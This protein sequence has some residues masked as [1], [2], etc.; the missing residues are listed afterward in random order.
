MVGAGILGAAGGYLLSTL[1]DIGKSAV[2]SA[3][4]AAKK[5]VTDPINKA[6][7]S[8]KRGPAPK[9]PESVAKSVGATHPVTGK[10]MSSERESGNYEPK[11]TYGEKPEPAYGG[12]TYA[13]LLAPLI[14]GVAWLA[15]IF[16]VGRFDIA[17]E[18]LSPSSINRQIF[19][20][21]LFIIIY[22][23]FLVLFSVGKEKA[24]KKIKKVKRYS[25]KK[26]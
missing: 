2:K 7:S 13:A 23:I 12:T 3:T 6:I 10:S 18:Q 20:L 26:K 1:T 17:A 5:L 16:L 4:G 22:S 14:I 11:K 21:S 15:Y 24:K 25:K 8:V 19:L 9:M